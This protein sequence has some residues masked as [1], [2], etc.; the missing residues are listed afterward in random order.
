MMCRT[1]WPDCQRPVLAKD[2]LPKVGGEVSCVVGKD[3]VERIAI[4]S[5]SNLQD[6]TDGQNTRQHRDHLVKQ[7][8]C[9]QRLELVT[10][11]PAHISR[12]MVSRVTLGT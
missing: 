1:S 2:R 11:R 4:L 7:P 12:G 10:Q 6:R 5:N 8:V 9:I 3:V